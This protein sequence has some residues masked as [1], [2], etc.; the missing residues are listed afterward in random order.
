MSKNKIKY[1]I[2]IAVILILVFIYSKNIKGEYLIIDGE[3]YK[4]NPDITT[5]LLL[6]IEKETE[7]ESSITNSNG[8]ADTIV[9][10][11]I[12][13]DLKTVDLYSIPRNTMVMVDIYDENDEYLT[14]NYLQLAMQYNYANS[15]EFSRELTSK[16]VS[17]IFYNLPI[18]YTISVAMAGIVPIVE[19]MAGV[20]VYM[21]KDYTYIHPAF[22]EG[23]VINLTGELA[24]LFLRYR[25][26]EDLQGNDDRNAR[27]LKFINALDEKFKYQLRNPSATVLYN[28]AEV[29]LEYIEGD[30]NLV[31]IYK[32]ASYEIDNE[33]KTIPGE[34]LFLGINEEF[35]IDDIAFKEFVL[36]T[37]CE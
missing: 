15:Q 6:G 14:Q 1:I 25:N 13:D 9:L 32:I 27:Q 29:C 2:I 23:E 31:P 37:F 11:V 7:S 10:A 12:N 28:I 33:L 30:I 20:E 19:Q 18:D 5:M 4:K 34:N 26:T 8:R 36:T 21:D 35:Y 3:E 22:I 24:E 17:E 16:R